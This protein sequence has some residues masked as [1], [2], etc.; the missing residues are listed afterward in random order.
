M[1]AQSSARR[2]CGDAELAEPSPMRVIAASNFSR[3]S[4]LSIA[5]FGR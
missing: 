5:F 3:S 4:A 2:R 1:V